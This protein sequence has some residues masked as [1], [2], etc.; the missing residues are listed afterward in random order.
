VTLHH[1]IVVNEASSEPG[2]ADDHIAANEVDGLVV[3][4]RDDQGTTRQAV[5]NFPLA[6]GSRRERSFSVFLLR[7]LR[8]LCAR[9][10]S[11]EMLLKK[12]S[13]EQ[14]EA[15]RENFAENAQFFGFALQWTKDANAKNRIS[16]SNLGITPN[17]AGVRISLFE[18]G[19][20]I[21]S[22][23]RSE[24]SVAQPDPIEN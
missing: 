4:F 11:V 14:C 18:Q 23:V 16:I 10:G 17:R 12:L 19:T 13:G 24:I 5:T 1:L 3:I 21:L 7:D 6:R 8:D 2:H 22:S 9:L 15:H 20:L